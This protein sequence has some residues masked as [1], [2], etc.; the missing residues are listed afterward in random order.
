MKRILILGIVIFLGV[1]M[2]AQAIPPSSIELSYNPETKVLHADIHH[3]SNNLRE[4][5]IRKVVIYVNEVEVNKVYYTN[6]TDA[7]RLSV[8]IP[9]SVED[10]DSIRLE[11]FCN[12]AGKGDQ[13][14]IYAEPEPAEEK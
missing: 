6:Q 7:S 14:M 8:D 9:L 10:G 13:T 12:D 4:H 5:H 2:K 11:A 3:I 1:V